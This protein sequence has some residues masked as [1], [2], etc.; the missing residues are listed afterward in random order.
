M[1]NLPISM[2]LARCT[3]TLF[4]N[5]NGC[6]SSQG[7]PVAQGPAA[8]RPWALKVLPKDS[9][10]VSWMG[11]GGG[12]GAEGQTLGLEAVAEEKGTDDPSHHAK[13]QRARSL[14]E[15]SPKVLGAWW[16]AANPGAG[17]SSAK[18]ALSARHLL[19]ARLPG[20][21]PRGPEMDGVGVTGWEWHV[22]TRRV[23][24]GGG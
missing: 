12:I 21:H 24:Q 9:Q 7:P 8:D 15:W 5:W 11:K 18:E 22:S 19:S 17:E 14:E 3:P 2:L 16:D 20:K 6:S 1:T 23:R 13:V 4:G 10:G